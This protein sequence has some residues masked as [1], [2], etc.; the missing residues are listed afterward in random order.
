MK[1]KFVFAA[2]FLAAA[3]ALVLGVNIQGEATAA[4][5]K[6]VY[7]AELTPSVADSDAFGAA[8]FVLANDNSALGFKLAVANLE[9]PIMAHIHVAA[10]PGGDGPPVLWLYPEGPPPQEIPGTFT[11]VLAGR[12]VTSD[13]LTGAA[14]VATL[15]DLRTAIEEGRAYVNVHTTANPG[16]EIRGPIE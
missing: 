8:V 7:T 5:L 2:L 13:A 4:S 14:G 11:G 10:E 1:K 3:L 15:A 6:T 9:D 12:V 16:G